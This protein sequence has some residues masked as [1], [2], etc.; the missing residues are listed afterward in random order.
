M[1][2]KR[3]L[4]IPIL[5][6][7]SYIVNADTPETLD[8]VIISPEQYQLKFENEYVR[9]V[10]YEILPGEKEKWHVHPT[11]VAYVLSGGNLKIT[12]ASGASFIVDDPTG[13]V[14]WQEAVGKHYG[15]NVGNTPIRIVFIEMK[16]IAHRNMDLNSYLKNEI[17][18]N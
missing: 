1:N 7:T 9:V 17:E 4:G 14:R 18:K 5:L 3:L 16:Q 13:Q 11:K 8:P 10:E 15:E 12:T 2:I 6:L